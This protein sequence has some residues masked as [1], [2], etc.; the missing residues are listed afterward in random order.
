MDVLALLCYFYYIERGNFQREEDLWRKVFDYDTKLKIKLELGM[1]DYSLQN[2]LSSLRKKGVIMGNRV[3]PAYLLP[4]SPT[5]ENFTV[6]FKFEFN[7]EQT[8]LQ[9]EADLNKP[10]LKPAKV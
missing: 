9:A 4:I 7:P 5:S 10:T 1:E 6:Y 3:S 8:A 2:L